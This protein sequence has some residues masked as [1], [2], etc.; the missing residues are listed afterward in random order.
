MLEITLV[1]LHVGQ[2][3]IPNFEIFVKTTVIAVV[4]K[5]FFRSSEVVGSSPTKDTPFFYEQ[6]NTHTQCYN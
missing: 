5:L 4:A 1:K 3:I 2:V 6:F